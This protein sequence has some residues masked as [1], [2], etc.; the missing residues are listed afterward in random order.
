MSFNG[1]VLLALH[2]NSCANEKLEVTIRC[3]YFSRLKLYG[4]SQHLYVK[5]G[6][7]YQSNFVLQ[8]FVK[9]RTAIESVSNLIYLRV[10]LE[11]SERSETEQKLRIDVVVAYK[12]NITVFTISANSLSRRVRDVITVNI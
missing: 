10:V 3:K 4:T 1:K 5:I 2:F 9:L 7:C 12:C 11:V 6:F 8:T